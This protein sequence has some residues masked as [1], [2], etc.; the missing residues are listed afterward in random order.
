MSLS[1]ST[2]V[3]TRNNALVFDNP[4]SADLYDDMAPT[5]HIKITGGNRAS[6]LV[7][8]ASYKITGTVNSTARTFLN[9]KCV[10]TGN[11]AR[12]DKSLG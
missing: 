2:C 9:M 8:N 3:V 12:F 11:T 6:A 10:E 1:I 5:M 4:T 7:L